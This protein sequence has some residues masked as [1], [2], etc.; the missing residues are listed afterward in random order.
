MQAAEME[1]QFGRPHP[2]NDDIAF[3]QQVLSCI[4]T[5]GQIII[6]R[7]I[8]IHI[9]FYSYSQFLFYKK[10]YFSAQVLYFCLLG[11]LRIL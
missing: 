11:W 2:C 6:Y 8:D 7:L 3:Y 5:C 10:K 4:D 9:D 1:S